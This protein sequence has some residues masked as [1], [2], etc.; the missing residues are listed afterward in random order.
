MH[1]LP[2]CPIDSKFRP[3]RP[4]FR[5]LTAQIFSVFHIGNVQQ[6]QVSLGLVPP[7]ISPQGILAGAARKIARAAGFEFGIHVV[8]TPVDC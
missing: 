3:F 2:N 7:A 6:A 8:T 5:G 1:K 4:D